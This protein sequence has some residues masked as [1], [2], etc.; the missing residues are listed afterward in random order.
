MKHCKKGL[1][2]HILHISKTLCRK[3]LCLYCYGTATKGHIHAIQS[4]CYWTVCFLEMFSH[5]TCLA[6]VL[7]LSFLTTT[8]TTMGHI[9]AELFAS[10]WYFH[11]I[12]AYQVFSYHCQHQLPRVTHNVSRCESQI[13][14]FASWWYFHTGSVWQQFWA[15]LLLPFPPRVTKLP[16]RVTYTQS[17]RMWKADKGETQVETY[18]YWYNMIVWNWNKF[19]SHN[20]ALKSLWIL[21]NRSKLPLL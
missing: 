18:P 5:A 21:P 9:H 19:N 1:I 2:V 4:S 16:P 10:W 12:S 20:S 3:C 8:T 13:I 6:T 17:E 15:S 11:T 14:V 7:R